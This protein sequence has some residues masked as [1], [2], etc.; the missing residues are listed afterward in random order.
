MK[1]LQTIKT[2]QENKQAGWAEEWK[3]KL[4]AAEP[5]QLQH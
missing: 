1:M 3:Y 2:W 4:E 5:D